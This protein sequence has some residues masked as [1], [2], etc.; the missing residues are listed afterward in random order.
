LCKPHTMANACGKAWGDGL[1][2][3]ACCV[4]FHATGAR[5]LP[6]AHSTPQLQEN[7]P[8][9]TRILMEF[10]DHVVAREARRK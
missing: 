1:P 9:Q 8:N 4:V 6:V 10:E 3:E 2:A 7:L 5:G